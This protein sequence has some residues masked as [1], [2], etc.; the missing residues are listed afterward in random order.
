MADI[1]DPDQNDAGTSLFR[2]MLP[3]LG[4]FLALLG[5]SIARQGVLSGGDPAEQRQKQNGKQCRAA[6]QS[7]R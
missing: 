5:W 6:N 1:P 2:A 4:L 7:S 3:H